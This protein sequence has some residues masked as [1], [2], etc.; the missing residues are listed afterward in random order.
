MIINIVNKVSGLERKPG[1][2]YVTA[3]CEVADYLRD[4]QYPY[5]VNVDSEEA[6]M[7]FWGHDY[8]MIGHDELLSDNEWLCK[9]YNRQCGIDN[10]IAQN[11]EICIRETKQEDIDRIYMM[12]DEECE[13]Y[14]E[15][16]P[17]LRKNEYSDYIKGLYRQYDM[18]G[19][20]MYVITHLKS[21]RV[22]GRIGLEP[23][24]DAAYLGYMIDRGYRGQGYATAA[25]DI[26]LEAIYKRY[27]G[28]CIKAK[29]DDKNIAS[30]HILKKA[31]II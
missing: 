30:V 2:L 9:I 17:I 8:I 24:E 15:S 20:G 25:V 23:K 21:G 1:I 31:G 6:C 12:Y 16:L 7:N 22:I 10:I 4:N 27:P 28:I 19:Y 11:K 26:F 29:V 13:K 5:V 14:L 18:Y 3:N